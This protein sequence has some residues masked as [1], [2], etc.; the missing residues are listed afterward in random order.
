[1][2][3]GGIAVNLYGIERST[4]DI[5]IVLKLKKENL[6]KFVRV[7]KALGLKPRLPVKLD[8]F[9]EPEK[10]KAWISDK[11]MVVF[12]LYDAKNPFFLIDTLV[13]IPFDFDK[14]YKQ[15]KRIKF[16]DTIIPVVP[17][18]ELI[19]MKEK[20]N[21]PQDRADVFHLRRIAEGWKNEREKI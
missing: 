9:V 10:R 8:D 12:S 13:E 17:I 16:E 1:M 18:D 7:A 21:R 2:V 4:A 14:V 11:G 6:L 20:S 5:D 15:R 3:A 19:E